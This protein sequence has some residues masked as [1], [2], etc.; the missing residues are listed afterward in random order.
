MHFMREMEILLSVKQLLVNSGVL[1]S[2]P[3]PLPPLHLLLLPPKQRCSAGSVCH[4]VSPE[5][6][7]WVPWGFGLT[8]E[9]LGPA[10]ITKCCTERSKGTLACRLMDS[11]K[12]GKRTSKLCMFMLARAWGLAGEGA[13][14]VPGWLQSTAQEGHSA[15]ALLCWALLLP[16]SLMRRAREV[17]SHDFLA[18]VCQN[19][20]I[21]SYQ[22]LHHYWWI[23]ILNCFWCKTW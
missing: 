5:P 9:D 7:L 12:F 16:L 2:P 11:L 17:F 4:H 13:G 3:G 20:E 6:L 15:E 8:G 10:A 19:I 22:W 21:L 18:M 23:I 1:L 14:E